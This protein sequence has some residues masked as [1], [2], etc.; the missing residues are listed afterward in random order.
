MDEQK[1]L[2]GTHDVQK[3]VEC[4]RCGQ[5]CKVSGP[6]GKKAKML[7][8]SKEPKGLCVNCAV[9]DWMRNTYPVNMLL[10]QSRS[11]PKSLLCPHI[12]EQFAGIMR[13]GFADAKPD[14]IDWQKI[15]DN[16]DLPFKNKVKGTAMNPASQDVLD[17]EPEMQ[18]RQEDFFKEEMVAKEEGFESLFEKQQVE[19]SRIIK[20]EFLPLLRK[21]NRDTRNET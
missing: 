18:A 8:H 4:K 5:R 3:T 14:E 2:F 12:Q 19:R 6:P 13:V 21:Q 16:W 9:H 7:R 15:V 11:G 20:E 17:M 1:G 10:A